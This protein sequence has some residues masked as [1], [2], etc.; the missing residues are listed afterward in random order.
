M[1]S[2]VA[3]DML[4]EGEKR[5]IDQVLRDMERARR[6]KKGFKSILGFRQPRA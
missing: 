1:S 2:R 4:E 5:G 6:R 3:D